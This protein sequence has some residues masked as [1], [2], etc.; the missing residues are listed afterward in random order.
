M[1]QRRFENR[2]PISS[3]ISQILRM[4]FATR[5][6]RS[7]TAPA[8]PSKTP[9]APNALLDQALR[10]TTPPRSHESRA[11]LASRNYRPL[12]SD[13]GD[14]Y[15]LAVIALQCGSSWCENSGGGGSA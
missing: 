5:N 12:L 7:V 11:P 9:D 1:E 2:K 4:D 14:N 3:P 13:C 8:S 6:S 10:N 15:T